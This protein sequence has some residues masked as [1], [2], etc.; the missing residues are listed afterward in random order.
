MKTKTME[1]PSWLK[2]NYPDEDID[3]YVCANLWR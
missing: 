2:I 1:F 3:N